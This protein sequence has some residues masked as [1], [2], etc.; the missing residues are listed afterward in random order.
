[1]NFHFD[2]MCVNSKVTCDVNSNGTCEDALEIAALY[3]F[4]PTIFKMVFF[5]SQ[6]K[7]LSYLLYAFCVVVI[8]GDFTCRRI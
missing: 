7:K 2:L 1:M 8:P 3:F 6:L 4:F 5:T